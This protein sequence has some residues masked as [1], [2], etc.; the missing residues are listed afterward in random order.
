VG[1]FVGARYGGAFPLRTLL[2]NLTGC[3]ALGLLAM[4]LLVPT[5][6]EVMLGLRS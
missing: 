6:R 4:S 1:R 2:I 5:H 3:F